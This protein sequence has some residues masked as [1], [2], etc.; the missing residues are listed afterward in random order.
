MTFTQH[1]TWHMTLVTAIAP[2]MAAMMAGT[3]WDPARRVPL[4]FSPLLACLV[5]FVAVWAWHT[6]RLHDAARDHTLW[7]AAEQATFLAV[8]LFLW[9]A[10]LG[11]HADERRA[12]AGSGVIALVLTFAHMTML[13]VLIA[14]SPRVLYGHGN[15]GMDDQQ[16]GAA[17]MIA[18]SAVVYPAAAL[19]LS[20]S[21]VT[22]GRRQEA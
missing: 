16:F 21:I 2:L 10:I 11:G 4:L 18:A 15:D 6:P 19:W 14:L 8:S 3:R 9:L 20:R 5:E 12:R 22:A 7:F 17:I 1:M 13:G